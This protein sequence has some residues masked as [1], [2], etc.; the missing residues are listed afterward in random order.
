MR[1]ACCWLGRAGNVLKAAAILLSW[2]T[3]CQ[4]LGTMIFRS[5]TTVPEGRMP[6]HHKVLKCLAW[7]AHLSARHVIS[8]QPSWPLNLQPAVYSQSSLPFNMS[9]HQCSRLSLYDAGLHKSAGYITIPA[10]ARRLPHR[11]ID[12]ASKQVAKKSGSVPMEH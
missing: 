3:C 9:C 1:I 8:A 10:A 4:Q 5:T 7:L 11:G 2:Y 6:K 12:A